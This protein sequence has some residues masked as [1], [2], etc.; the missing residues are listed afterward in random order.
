MALAAFAFVI[1]LAG[2]DCGCHDWRV[3]AVTRLY[4]TGCPGRMGVATFSDDCR[5]PLTLVMT[6]PVLIYT[7]PDSSAV[8]SE[9]GP[10]RAR[11]DPT[12]KP[13]IS[14]VF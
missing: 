5:T 3:D 12:P 10:I 6:C 14:P 11:S 8:R 1:D 7:L 9:R 2:C 4:L 13:G